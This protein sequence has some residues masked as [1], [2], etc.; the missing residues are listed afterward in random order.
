M[1]S[2]AG[3]A[4]SIIR[5]KMRT[6]SGGELGV[7]TNSIHWPEIRRWSAANLLYSNQESLQSGSARCPDQNSPSV[8]TRET[9]RRTETLRLGSVMVYD[10]MQPQSVDWVE[11]STAS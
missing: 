5:A 7:S 1:T 9:A 2:L 10:A 8:V 11:E 4:P 3:V 6:G